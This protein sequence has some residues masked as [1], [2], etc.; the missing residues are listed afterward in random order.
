[1]SATTSRCGARD[2]LDR[3]TD[4]R[5][6]GAHRRL[7]RGGV[8]DWTRKDLDGA[9]VDGAQFTSMTGYVEGDLID[10]AGAEMLLRTAEESIARR[11]GSARR[12]EPA[13]YRADGRDSRYA[14]R[15]GHR[16]DVAGR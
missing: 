3:P 12:P 10:P 14:G 13:R 16:C 1:M 7:G 5:A 4:R 15:D 11:V 9:V 6:R 2:G 8:W